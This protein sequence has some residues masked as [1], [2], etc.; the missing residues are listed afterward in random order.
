VDRAVDL[1][2]SP[3]QRL[4]NFFRRYLFSPEQVLS[5]VNGQ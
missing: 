2:D 3:D 1:L 5:F 4:Y